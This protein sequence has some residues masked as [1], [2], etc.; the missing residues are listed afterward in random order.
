MISSIRKLLVSGPTLLDFMAGMKLYA[1]LAFH[2]FLQDMMKETIRSVNN[3]DGIQQNENI[4]SSYSRAE[5]I[6]DGLL[7]DVSTWAKR[8]GIKFPVAVSVSIWTE[9]LEPD[10]TAKDALECHATRLACFLLTLRSE[11]MAADGSEL[12]YPYSV[13]IDGELTYFSLYVTLLPGDNFEPVLTNLLE[14]ED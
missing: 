9:I 1:G 3:M 14:G 7:F 2:L 6:S 8:V 11:L 10:E 13:P 4:I 12:K 5:A